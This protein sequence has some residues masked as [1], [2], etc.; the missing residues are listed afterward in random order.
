MRQQYPAAGWPADTD[1]ASPDRSSPDDGIYQHGVSQDGVSQ[2]GVSQAWADQ[3]GASE[4]AHRHDAAP[5]DQVLTN[6]IAAAVARHEL[7]WTLPRPSVLARRYHVTTSQVAAAIDELAARHLVRLQPDGKACR[8]SP[9]EYMFELAGQH[10][11]AARVEPLHGQ[12]TCKSHSVAWHPVLADIESAVDLAAGEPAC[13]VQTLWTVGGEPA[14]ATTSYLAGPAAE[15]LLAT[16]DGADTGSLHAILPMPPA[17]AA[18]AAGVAGDL[19]SGPAA[20][21]RWLLVPH[22]LRIEM[23]QPP[24]WAAGAL[25]L[26]ACDSAISIT[27]RYAEPASANPAALTV[28]ALR[29]DQFRVIVDSVVTSLTSDD[30]GRPGNRA[31]GLIAARRAAR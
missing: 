21:P 22:E 8:I 29:P 17:C 27:V 1:T 7:G 31:G 11:L 2:D 6:R 10:G 14:A 26:S 30:Y 15:P 4:D 5:A 24:P 19:A 25:R 3:H 28:A 20:P 16:L 13:I 9:S 18:T 12:L 23:K